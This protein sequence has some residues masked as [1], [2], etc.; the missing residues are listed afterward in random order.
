MV[1]Y[2]IKLPKWVETRLIREKG[3]SVEKFISNFFNDLINKEVVKAMR[4]KQND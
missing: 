3:I 4:E 2:K 1:E